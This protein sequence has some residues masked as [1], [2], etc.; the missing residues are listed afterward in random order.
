MKFDIKD[1]EDMELFSKTAKVIFDTRDDDSERSKWHEFRAKTIG[2]SEIAKVAG[3]SKYGSPLTVFNE[4][5]GLVEKFKGNI[6]TKFGTRMEDVIKEF[7]IDDFKE[8]TGID[9]E[10]YNYPFMMIDKELPFLSANIDG[11]AK[12]SED[13]IYWENRDT[14]EIKF[15]PKDELIGI[16]IKTAGE[17]SKSNWYDDEIPDDYLC[18]IYNYLSITNLNYFVIIYLIGKEVKWKVVPRNEE[19]IKALREIGKDFWN[20]H[21]LTKVPPA[22]SGIKKETDEILEQQALS[23]EEEVNINNDLLSRYNFL[24]DKI[25]ALEKEKE[26]AKQEIFLQMKNSKKATDGYFKVSRYVVARETIDNKLLKEK[27]P[28]TYEAVLK[29]TTEYV[30]MKISKCK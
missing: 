18:Q 1:I 5:L 7:F 11:L 22:P 27:Y 17:F 21:I 15:I 30:N 28:Q 6:H 4:K 3:L 26:Q 16:E 8:E 25:K 13:Y 14:A 10:V 20:N 23:D 19:D 29:G 12:F 2:G 24:A 9:V